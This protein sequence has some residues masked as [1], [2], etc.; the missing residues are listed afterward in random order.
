MCWLRPRSPSADRYFEGEIDDVRIYK[1]ALS[2]VEIG[3]LVAL[4]PL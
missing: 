2:P 1:R 4:Q 3:A